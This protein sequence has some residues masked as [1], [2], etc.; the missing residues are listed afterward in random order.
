MR[1]AVRGG[2]L[3]GPE[4][5]P[6]G[7]TDLGSAAE[8]TRTSTGVSPRRPERR[9]YTNFTTAAC[10]RAAYRVLSGFYP[11]MGH[12][13]GDIDPAAEPDAIAVLP[14]VQADGRA[15]RR[16]DPE[17]VRR[18]VAELVAE[19]RVAPRAVDER[20]AVGPD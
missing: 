15:G 5:S 2:F 12:Q 10:G 4:V 1:T 3:A 18:P 9:V 7:R 19:I 8:R 6:D 16:E 17:D 13:L 14:W 11:D 20:A